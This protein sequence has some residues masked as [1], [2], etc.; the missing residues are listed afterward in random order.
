MR[1]VT[2]QGPGEV[3]IEEVADPELTSPDEA[4]I[5]VEA[6]GVCG[7]DLHIFHGRVPVDPGTT[8]GHEYV[9]TVT[10]VGDAVTRVAVGDRV[11]GCFLCACGTCAN[12]VRGDYHR[13]ERGRTFGHGKNLGS[14]G[15]TQADQALIPFA[16]LT[17]RKVPEGM[18]AETALFAGDVAGTGYHA[19]AHGGMQEGDTVAVLGLGPVGL[20]A[21]QAAV[22]GGAT[23]VFAVDSVEQ[24]LDLAAQ[25]GATPI[26]LTEGDPKREIRAATDGQG[27]DVVV[28]A[29]G[30]PAAV[31]AAIS[32]ARNAGT[33]SGIGVQVGSA[34]LNLGLAWLKG[35]DLRLG[36][37][38]VIAHVDRV[39]ALLDSG[40]LD[41]TP[42]V[43]HHM[44]L[45]EAVEAYAIYD[46]REAL[47][48]L[49]TP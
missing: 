10:A 49:L 22:A 36:Q 47:K 33:V 25:F 19:I 46:R 43:T 29:V 8:I 39:L 26:H 16:D 42:L 4:I 15:G 18:S 1:A 45:D 13:C 3:R 12:C 17:L 41:P 9:G 2:Y 34:E 21:V 32:L 11:L 23:Q 40:K 5:E 14:L 38:N 30:A 24:R 31:D 28:E 35:L 20:C 7:S 27:A 44:K 37:A 48:V 6:T